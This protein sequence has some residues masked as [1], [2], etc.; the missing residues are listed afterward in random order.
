MPLELMAIY[1]KLPV[2]LLVA[3]RLGGL[4]MFQPLLG[5][6]AV[7]QRLR[8]LLVLGLA[9]LVTPLVTV[10]AQGPTTLGSLALAL[11]CELLLGGVIGLAGA[12]IFIGLQMGGQLIAQESG[13]AFGQIADPNTGVNQAVLGAFYMQLAAVIYMIVGGHREL[14][15]ACLDTF[16]SIPLLA[17][18]DRFLVGAEFLVD[19]MQLG[20]E[21]A[22]RIA[23]P[24]V[25]TLFLVNVAMGFISRTVP[26]LNITTLGFTFKALIGFLIMAVSLPSA[27]NAF[28]EGLEAIFG[29]LRQLLTT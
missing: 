17:V 4:I 9:A 5:A 26:Q 2:F 22:V 13:L 7:P 6:M 3:A 19:A 8:L 25:L 23:A 12:M 14:L 21:L 18:G 11:G 16:H 24:A 20:G 10:P 29:W 15:L 28:L 27:M 1:F